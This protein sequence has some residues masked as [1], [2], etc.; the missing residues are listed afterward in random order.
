MAVEVYVWLPKG[1]NVGHA[2]MKVTG[3]IPGGDM[4]LSRWPGKVSEVIIPGVGVARRYADDVA[5]EGGPPSVVRLTKLDET[6]IKKAIVD[7]HT[8]NLY[9]FLSM[10]CSSQVKKCLDAGITGSTLLNLGIMATTGLAVSYQANH[11]PWG[12]YQYAQLIHA[13]YG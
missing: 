10:N 8:K 12:V 3:G 11:T 1:T 4:Y 5:S 2:A 6:A 13:T 7:S 9:Q